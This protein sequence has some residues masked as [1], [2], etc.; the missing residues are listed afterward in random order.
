MRESGVKSQFRFTIAASWLR[1]RNEETK[2][3]SKC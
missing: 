3:R 2:E 1:H